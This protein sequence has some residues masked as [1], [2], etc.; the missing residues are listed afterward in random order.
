[1]LRAGRKPRKPK[2]ARFVVVTAY[3]AHSTDK[4][5]LIPHTRGQIL[6]AGAWRTSEGRAIAEEIGDYFVPR[7]QRGADPKLI[8]LTKGD[9]RGFGEL[10]TGFAQGI[11]WGS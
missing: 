10:C 1:M 8:G 6:L 11:T 3:S 9:H 2:E 5:L 7:A 4:L